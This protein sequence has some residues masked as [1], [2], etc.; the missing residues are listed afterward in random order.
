MKSVVLP[1]TWF[2]VLACVETDQRQLLITPGHLPQI[3]RRRIATDLC[4]AQNL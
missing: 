4:N 3:S 1:L 2:V